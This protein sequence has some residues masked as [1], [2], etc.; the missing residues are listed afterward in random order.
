MVTEAE[1]GSDYAIIFVPSDSNRTI[2]SSYSVPR[3]TVND[4]ERHGNTN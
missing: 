2:A 3:L 1:E 4:E